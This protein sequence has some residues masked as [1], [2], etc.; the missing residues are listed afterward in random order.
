LNALDSLGDPDNSRYQIFTPVSG[1]LDNSSNHIS[2]PAS[3]GLGEPSDDATT[4][5]SGE[6]NLVRLDGVDGVG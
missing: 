5:E 1:D 3:S 4:L 6:S 2:T